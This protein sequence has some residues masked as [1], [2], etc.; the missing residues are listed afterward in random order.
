[1]S[2]TSG[3]ESGS[4]VG[5]APRGTAG[6]RTGYGWLVFGHL[7]DVLSALGMAV[8]VG[9]GAGL[10]FHERRRTMIR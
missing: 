9:S 10:I 1:M 2:T 3:Y 7:P 8:I 6:E 5:T 4:D